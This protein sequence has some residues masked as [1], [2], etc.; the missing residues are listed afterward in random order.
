MD[1]GLAYLEGEGRLGGLRLGVVAGLSPLS[2]LDH[3]SCAEDTQ[4]GQ[5]P[6]QLLL[7]RRCACA[8]K[9]QKERR[10]PAQPPHRGIGHAHARSCRLVLDAS[11]HA[12]CHGPG[13]AHR[14]DQARSAV[15]CRHGFRSIT[16]EGTGMSTNLLLADGLVQAGSV[17][18]SWVDE[19]GWPGA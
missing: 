11:A 19:L 14:T 15:Q 10:Q 4:R 16:R 2:I 13:R 8:S 5:S 9:R 17:L 12:D 3:H 1:T 6:R 18:A 7:D